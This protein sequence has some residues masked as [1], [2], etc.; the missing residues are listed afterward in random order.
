VE[1]VLKNFWGKAIDS[2]GQ[3]I[4]P[5]SEVDRTTIP[6]NQSWITL[7]I[8]TGEAS[9]KLEW[10]QL[11]PLV[12]MRALTARAR[13]EGMTDKQ[14]AFV[15]MLHGTTQGAV[16]KQHQGRACADADKVSAVQQG[17]AT[18]KT[19]AP[20]LPNNSLQRP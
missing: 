17:T 7:A 9:G 16:T 3:S 10:C 11:N 4:E 20:V 14:V 12:T 6:V 2:K 5:I 1:F 13:S 15:T 18:L 8:D 19:L